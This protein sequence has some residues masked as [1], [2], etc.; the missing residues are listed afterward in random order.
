MIL[1]PAIDLKDG[2]CVRL[3]QGRF[4]QV[5]VFNADPGDQARQLA[6]AG[7]QWIHVVDLDGAV[8]GATRNRQA[9]QAILGAGL[10]VQLGGGIRDMAAVERW[11]EAG[12]ARVILGTAALRDPAFT[13]AAAAAFPG[14][15]AVGIDAR[16][17]RVAVEGWLETSDTRAV[18]LARLYEDAGV[19]ALI[20]TDIARDGL[21]TGANLALCGEIADA[22]SIP[23]IVSGGVAGVADITAARLHSGR[24]IAGMVLGRALYDGDISAAEALEAAA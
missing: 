2:A 7:F 18:D 3:K 17:G 4:D 9:V 16:E 20:V 24:A 5:T 19:A 10:P 6:A 11:L 22:V 13:R 14:Q 21:K 8:A 15:V 1:Y 12:L 23:V